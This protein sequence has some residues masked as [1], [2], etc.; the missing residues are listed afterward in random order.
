[1]MTITAKEFKQR[2][3]QFLDKLGLREVDTLLAA[4]QRVDATPGQVLLRAGEKNDSMYLLWDGSLEIKMQ[5]DGEEVSLGRLVPG[6]AFGAVALIEPGSALVTAIAVEA[7]VV[8]RLS[9]EQLADL[10]Q[11]QPRVGGLVLR[12]LSLDLAER[13]RLYEEGMVARGSPPRD[14]EE[15]AL[16][17]RPLLGVK[18]V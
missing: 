13:L 10:R 18:N 9:H 1:M 12:A 3:P 16:L 8:L 11:R 5:A 6:Q 14:A 7:S 4:T 17:C 2:F 15:F